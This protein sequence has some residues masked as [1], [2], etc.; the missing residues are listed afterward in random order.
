MQEFHL[1]EIVLWWQEYNKYYKP[2]GL[3]SEFLLFIHLPLSA[4]ITI[5]CSYTSIPPFRLHSVV[6]KHTVNF[7]FLAEARFNN[8]WPRLHV[9]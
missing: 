7:I 8:P 2:L 1:L 6:P 5:A 9:T 4:E 3:S